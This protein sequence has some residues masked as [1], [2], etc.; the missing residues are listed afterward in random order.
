MKFTKAQATGNDFVIVAAHMVTGSLESLAQ[1][2]CVR[3]FGI[4]SDGLLVVTHPPFGPLTMHMFNPDGTEDMCGNGLRCVA[5]WIADNKLASGMEFDI[6]TLDGRHHAWVDEDM[7]TVTM[8]QP[9]WTPARVPVISQTDPAVDIPV[10]TPWGRVAI[11]AVN[12]GSTHTVVTVTDLP[13]H[14]ATARM[15]AYLETHQLFPQRTSVLFCKRE[16]KGHY[17]IRIWERGA[18]ETLGCGTGACAV[19][20]VARLHGDQADW[21]QVSSLGGTLQ[22]HFRQDNSVLLRGPARVV[23]EGVWLVDDLLCDDSVNTERR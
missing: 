13:D 6:D 12:T 16:A 9:V 11:S 14:A 5:R 3:R 15:G 22:V 21:Y 2:M 4:G 8:A 7:V 20:A 23:Y 18:G 19:A 10:E 17:V 1:R